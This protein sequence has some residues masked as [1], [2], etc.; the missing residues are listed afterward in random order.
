VSVQL[1]MC[2]RSIST[3]LA[4]IGPI[5]RVCTFVVV[6]GLVCCKGLTTALKAARV[7][8]VAGMAE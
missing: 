7:G 5:S 2:S 1:G 3:V 4:D 8:S 6:F